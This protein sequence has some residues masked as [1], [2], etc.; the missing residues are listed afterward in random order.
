MVRLSA[1]FAAA[2]ALAVP[3]G[4]SPRAA[5]EAA[6]SAVSPGPTFAISGRGWGHGIGMSQYGARG[7]AETGATYSQILA[8]YYP[9][10]QLGRAPVARVRVLLLEGRKA[11]TIASDRPFRARDGSGAVH[12]L[13][14]PAYKLGPTLELQV[15]E[16]A[17]QALPGPLT[18]QAAGAPLKVND[19]AYRGSLE[20]SVLK[21][22]LRVINAVGLE[23]Y[24][25]G[26]VPDEMPEDWPAEALKAQAVVARSYALAVRKAGDFDLYADVRSQVYNGIGAEEPE[27]TDAID[28]TAGEVLL[29]GGKVATT[30]FY[31]TSGGRTASIEDE[32]NSDPVP[33]LVSVE[34]PYDSASPY[35]RWGPVPFTA[36]KVASELKVK[37]PVLDARVETNA[38]QRAET[39]VLVTA[40]GETAVPAADVRAELGLRSTWFRVG[41]LSLSP[42]DRPVTHGARA[43]LA[44]IARGIKGVT[45][46]RRAP[47]SLVW[48]PVGPVK[49]AKGGTVAVVVKPSAPVHYRLS[50]GSLHG[51][52]VRVAVAPLVRL[53]APADPTTLRGTVR[54][55]K[56]GAT[57]LI[58]RQDGSAWLTVGEAA[59]GVDGGFEVS[60]DLVPGIY[61][62]RYAPGGGFAI[63]LSAVLNVVAA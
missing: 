49:P 54:P 53:K 13:A 55:A 32:W 21:K 9:G 47:E 60:L 24:L 18:F 62:A 33:Y 50:A 52:V 20:V 25:Y 6:P 16:G 7:Y 45:L 51:P 2:V 31:S 17:P 57:V 26:V 12:Q 42:P 61:R 38:S 40:T 5:R 56:E 28:Q 58:Q 3:G 39:L 63:G 23:G 44:G 15:G 48:E 14:G 11:L 8:H 22:K 43:K 41:V 30:Y 29:Y 59:V 34:D 1:A 35:H 36:R 46:E 4:A 37:G 27:T 19:K 10:T